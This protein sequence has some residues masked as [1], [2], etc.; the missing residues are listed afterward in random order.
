MTD[1][2]NVVSFPF[3]ENPRGVIIY[4]KSGNMSGQIMPSPWTE[5]DTKLTYI[6]YFGSY[7]INESEGIVEHQ[8]EGSLNPKMIGINQIRYFSFQDGKMVLKTPVMRLGD[9]KGFLT[10][11]WKKE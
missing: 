6:A 3:G 4:D 2:E 5:T 7:K 1:L 9:K 8:V 10:L 11:E